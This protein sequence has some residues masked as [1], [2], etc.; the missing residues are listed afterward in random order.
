MAIT[1][2]IIK[3]ALISSLLAVFLS[4]NLKTA[5][6]QAGPPPPPNH[7]Q[8]GD[9]PAGEGG[10]APIGDGILLLSVLAV[11]YLGV[12]WRRASPASVEIES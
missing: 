12:K 2:N 9:Q 8:S 5:N 1:Q 6:C 3:R 11:G 4:L 10:G 7:D